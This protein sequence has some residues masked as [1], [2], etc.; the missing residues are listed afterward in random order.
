MFVKFLGLLLLSTS[1]CVYSWFPPTYPAYCAKNM[2]TRAIPE[3]AA[4]QKQQVGSLAQVQAII[5]HG[6]RTP[7]MLYP[8][9]NNYSVVWNNCNVTD[10]MLAS[11]SY[12]S[13]SRPAPWLFRKLYDGSANFLGGNCLTGQ[14]ILEGYQQEQTLGT[15]LYSAYLD[16][17]DGLNL[18]PTNQWEEIDTANEVYLRSDDEERTLMSGQVMLHGMFNV[19]CCAAT[20]VFHVHFLYRCQQS[21]LCCGTQATMI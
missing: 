13:Q 2:S 5:R 11:P 8:C 20:S 14:L 10:L 18:F 9:W 1:L 21:R 19:C 15:L 12:N 16:N 7:Y 6:A 4:S 17:P 3:L